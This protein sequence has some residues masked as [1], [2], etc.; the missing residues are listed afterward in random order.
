MEYYNL[1]IMLHVD[2]S[3]HAYVRTKPVLD[4]VTLTQCNFAAER[5]NS[6]VSMNRVYIAFILLYLLTESDGG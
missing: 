3:T 4:G 2:C 1:I 6:A 5:N